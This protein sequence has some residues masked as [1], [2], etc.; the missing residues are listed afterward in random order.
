M[1]DGFSSS[2]TGTSEWQKLS[3]APV[4]GEQV[5]P[6]QLVSLCE[7]IVIVASVANALRCGAI[8]DADAVEAFARTPIH[9]D[10]ALLNAF[11]GDRPTASGLAAQLAGRVEFAINASAAFIFE[12]NKPNDKSVTPAGLSFAWRRVCESLHRFVALTS[13]DDGTLRL[14]NEVKVGRWPRLHQNS[15]HDPEDRRRGSR[16]NKDEP[17]AVSWHGDSRDATLADISRSGMRMSAMGD[18]VPPPGTLVSMILPSG[19]ILT[20]SIVWAKADGA[21]VQL[22][23]E[24]S[25]D[26]DLLSGNA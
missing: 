16:I 2:E 26:N 19:Q 18:N 3:S 15:R 9:A 1:A 8:D 17:V 12:A 4:V 11:A 6:H 20:G 13:D 14:L 7:K 24:L 22:F 10:I 25:P 21:G 23:T 5:M